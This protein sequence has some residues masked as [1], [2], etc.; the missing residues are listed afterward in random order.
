MT[1]APSAPVALFARDEGKGAP[2]LLLH[3]VGG[4][5]AVWDGVLPVL[6]RD[7]RVLAPDLRGHG[8]SPLPDG[9]GFSFEELEGD[10][11]A[12][13]DAKGIESAYVVGL[14]GG[15]LLALRLT[16]DHPERV[17]GLVMVSGAAYTD[18]HTRAITQR[19]ADTLEKEGRDALGLRMLKDLYYPDW[20][21]AHLDFADTVRAA[22]MRQDLAPTTRWAGA[23]E[24][25]DER[26]RIAS[27]ARPTLIVQAMDD[28]VVDASHGRILRQSIPDSQIRIL[29]QT[30]HMVPIE[31]PEETSAA[32]AEFVRVVEARRSTGP[33]ST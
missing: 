14:S 20:I 29:P 18:N 11:L 33:R 10:L 7:L 12:L 4:S 30:G 31:R 28:Q 32:V 23:M 17:R 3:T 25:F 19:W 24:R 2:L 22:V 27:V 26:A 8:R 13:L 21:E 1:D 15:A 6:A 5:H 16:L 9:A